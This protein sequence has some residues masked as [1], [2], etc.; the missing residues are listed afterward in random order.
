MR[1]LAM[2][3]AMLL[4]TTSAVAT[5]QDIAFARGAFA[6]NARLFTLVIENRGFAVLEWDG[7]SNQWRPWSQPANGQPVD[8]EMN[9][10]DV[11]GPRMITASVDIGPVSPQRNWEERYQ[12]WSIAIDDSNRTLSW[13][14][15]TVET[16]NLRAA[17]NQAALA[18]ASFRTLN[19]AALGAQISPAYIAEE[20][21]MGS[22]TKP[23]AVA[24]TVGHGLHVYK[25]PSRGS[26]RVRPA[27]ARDYNLNTGQVGATDTGWF[28][29]ATVGSGSWPGPAIVFVDDHLNPAGVISLPSR[30][31]PI[32]EEAG[33]ARIVVDGDFPDAWLITRSDIL[34]IR[35]S[36]PVR[37]GRIAA[38]ADSRSLFLTNGINVAVPVR[39]T[40]VARERA[41]GIPIGRM[42]L[43]VSPLTRLVMVFM[44]AGIVAGLIAAG[45]RRLRKGS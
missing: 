27:Y 17:G 42:L 16:Y 8:G 15:Q 4:A 25:L 36:A 9:Y 30:F 35:W 22:A 31:S 29:A 43:L 33:D 32:M 10:A 1:Q 6:R 2:F 41:V 39:W 28:M 34:K 23:G 21:A 7:R 5:S 14:R 26:G 45:A 3:I 12:L 40:R 38:T 44:I 37:F 20:Y 11:A 24:F 18:E 13:S 19:A